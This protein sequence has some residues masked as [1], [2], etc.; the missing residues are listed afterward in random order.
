MV[1][2]PSLPTSTRAPVCPSTRPVFLLPTSASRRF[3][4]SSVKAPFSF[5]SLLPMADPF[6]KLP[7]EIALVI[8]KAVP[9]LPSLCS[10]T[11]ASR[12]MS[13]LSKECYIE[14]VE[15]VLALNY[16]PE[17]Q[18]L[19]RMLIEVRS[20]PSVVAEKLDSVKALDD[21]L[22]DH[23]NYSIGSHPLD[24]L[25]S[26][27]SAVQAGLNSACHMQRL[28]MLFFKMHLTR[29]DNI[30][31]SHHLDLSSRHLALPDSHTEK[32]SDGLV[33]CGPP[34]WTE[35]PRV[36]RALWRLLTVHELI[37]L[38][39]SHVKPNIELMGYHRAR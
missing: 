11:R 12:R 28:N 39:H 7:A 15:A 8:L 27:F 19:I 18:S 16:P 33:K 25:S 38:I 3:T 30:D 24:E 26:Q 35:E 2:I 17:L 20:N 32:L 4:N 37:N 34:S 22:Q 13:L 1:S 21:Y 10:L 36:N 9:D 29:I 14:V 5:L 23:I 31:T 6:S